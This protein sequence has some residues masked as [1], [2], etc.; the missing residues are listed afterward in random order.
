MT[1]PGSPKDLPVPAASGSIQPWV[2]RG[3]LEQLP[4]RQAAW[5]I[6]SALAGAVTALAPLWLFQPELALALAMGVGASLVDLRRVWAAPLVIAAVGL[7]GLI[8][9]AMGWP[10]VVGASAV[11]GAIG[12]YLFPQRT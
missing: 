2:E 12:A 5:V 7:T 4:K 3:A 10:V 9:V 1:V 8:C 11:A 6:G